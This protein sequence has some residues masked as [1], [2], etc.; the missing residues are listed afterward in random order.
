MQIPKGGGGSEKEK[1][2][3]NCTR[4]ATTG[5]PTICVVQHHSIHISWM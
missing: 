1:L 4:M 3:H 5:W 2:P